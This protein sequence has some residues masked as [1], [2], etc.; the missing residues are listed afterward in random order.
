MKF[1]RKLIEYSLNCTVVQSNP[2]TGF[3]NAGKIMIKPNN[4]NNN[5]NNQFNTS[6]FG[7]NTGNSSVSHLNFRGSFSEISWK[8]RWIGT[9]KHYR[10]PHK[11]PFKQYECTE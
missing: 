9:G 6:N 10:E 5:V 3:M 11:Q 8:I 7:M 1:R 4:P 2:Q